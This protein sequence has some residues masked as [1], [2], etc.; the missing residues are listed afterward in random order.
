MGDRMK[1]YL[2]NPADAAFSLEELGRAEGAVYHNVTVL[3]MGFSHASDALSAIE[4][5]VFEQRRFTLADLIKAA[6]ENYEGTPDNLKLYAAL[7]RS[8]KYA[9]GS[10]LAA[11]TPSLS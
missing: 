10:D 6:K 11:P 5:L 2:I 4:T 7:L 9:N 3:A 1:N 8:P